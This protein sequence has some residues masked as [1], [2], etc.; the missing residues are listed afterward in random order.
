MGIK[1]AIKKLLRMG[2]EK[3]MEVTEARVGKDDVK[4]IE[5]AYKKQIG[6]KDGQLM[7]KEEEIAKKNEII[8]N[9]KEEKE[10][11]EKKAEEE[12]RERLKE[13]PFVEKEKISVKDLMDYL[14]EGE[15]RVLSREHRNLGKLVDFHL[16]PVGDKMTWNIITNMDGEK[17]NIMDGFELMNM[18]HRPNGFIDALENGVMVV[19]RS[20]DSRTPTPDTYVIEGGDEKSV[21][22]FMQQKKKQLDNLYNNLMRAKKSETEERTRRKLEKLDQQ[23]QKARADTLSKETLSSV[24]DIID[25]MGRIKEVYEERDKALDRMSGLENQVKSMEKTMTK[26]FDRLEETAPKDEVERARSELREDL[27]WFHERVLEKGKEKAG[28][29]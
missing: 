27:E 26:V 5:E 29:E 9:L 20:F 25:Q 3:R 14:K 22:T 2:G 18:I 21:E 16:V 24:K 4:E 11:L 15:I 28:G 1:D 10:K 17:Y 19:N 13:K 6:I 23:S 7:D 12:R 8:K